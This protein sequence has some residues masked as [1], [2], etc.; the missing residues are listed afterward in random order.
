MGVSLGLNTTLFMVGNTMKIDS[1]FIKFNVSEDEDNI[2][3]KAGADGY[4]WKELTMSLEELNSNDYLKIMKEKIKVA[5]V[6]EIHVGEYKCPSCGTVKKTFLRYYE[7][8]RFCGFCG[9]HLKLI[10]DKL[11][12]IAEIDKICGKIEGN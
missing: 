9:T 8:F 6:Q 2:R 3:I 4:P 10:G 1:Y 5:P 12:I 7:G 11:E